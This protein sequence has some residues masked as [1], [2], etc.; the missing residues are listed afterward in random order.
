AVEAQY[1]GPTEGDLRGEH[2]RAAAEIK[3]A[4][5]GLRIEQ[6]HQRRPLSGDVAEAAVV[7]ATVPP[8][9]ARCVISQDDQLSFVRH[10]A[11][12]AVVSVHFRARL[13]LRHT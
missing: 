3:D 1:L 12:V 7:G 11:P 9:Q 10:R 4:L 5:A 2:A 13:S 6:V 8:L